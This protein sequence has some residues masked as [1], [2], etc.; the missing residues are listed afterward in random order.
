MQYITPEDLAPF[1]TIDE[2]KALAMIA[3]AESMA[4]SVAPCLEDITVDLT[5]AQ[6]GTVKAVLRRAVL[7]WN[8]IGTGAV[9]QQSAGP[10]QQSLDT[11]RSAPKS[12][13]WPSEIAELQAVCKAVN[14]STPK[15]EQVFTINTAGPRTGY[16]SPIC[17]LHFGGLMCS[18]G[19]SLNAYRGPLPEFGE[20]L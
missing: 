16:H 19:S 6:R 8:E 7:R 10:F 5:D 11:T 18:C 17:D 15:G 2:A 9:T 4:M 20:V 12:L 1:A 14:G 3:D 13:F